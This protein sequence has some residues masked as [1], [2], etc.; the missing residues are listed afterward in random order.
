M[1]LVRCTSAVKYS[2]TVLTKAQV[3]LASQVETSNYTES[4]HTEKSY[5]SLYI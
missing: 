2:A 5:S 4:V 3:S 1:N